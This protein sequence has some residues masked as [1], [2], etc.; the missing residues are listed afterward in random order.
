MVINLKKENKIFSV[1]QRIG[2]SFMFP[3]ALLPVAGLLLGIGSSFTNETMIASYN[4]Q[5]FLGA[6][7]FMNKLLTVMSDT[8]NIIF[9]N[10]PIIFAM[11]VALGMAEKEKATA[12]LSAAIAFFV[13]HQTINSLLNI[14]SLPISSS[15]IK[16]SLLYIN[17]AL[18]SLPNICLI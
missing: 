2:R 4:L 12:T 18:E 3:I 11:G 16:L 14:N 1:L 17:I 7:T 8:G 15:P 13:M 9:A 10:L 5:G 6:G